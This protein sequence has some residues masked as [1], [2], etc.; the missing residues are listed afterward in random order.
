MLVFLS[1]VYV[2]IAVGDPIIK[3]GGLDPIYRFNLATFVFG[4]CPKPGPGF[5]TSCVTVFLFSV[6]WG[7]KHLFFFIGGIVDQHWL[8]ILFTIEYF[9]ERV[10]NRRSAFLWVPTIL[11]FLLTCSFIRTKHVTYKGFYKKLARS[12]ISRSTI[13]MMSFH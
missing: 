12:L 5:L 10:F 3:R 8:N 13:K 9:G 7:E 1:F 11:L 2:C 4:A 6:I